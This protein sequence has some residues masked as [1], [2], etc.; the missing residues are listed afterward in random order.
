MPVADAASASAPIATNERHSG[1]PGTAWT[2]P[3]SPDPVSGCCVTSLTHERTREG[4]QRSERAV[5]EPLRQQVELDDVPDRRHPVAPADLLPLG[6]RSPRIADR[7]LEYPGVGA[8][9]TS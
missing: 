9:E 3:L 8:R 7:N 6:V 2:A 4:A 5:R 1:P